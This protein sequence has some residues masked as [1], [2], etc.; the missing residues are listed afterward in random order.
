MI[1]NSQRTCY[2]LLFFIIIK[3]N[4]KELCVC[5]TILLEDLWTFSNSSSSAE[6]TKFK[7]KEVYILIAN[8]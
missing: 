5:W 1:I 3:E 6:E 8:L 2:K 4:I 7:K